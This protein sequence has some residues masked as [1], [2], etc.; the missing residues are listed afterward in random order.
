LK[1]ANRL[2]LLPI[3]ETNRIGKVVSS[4]QES[5]LLE[6]NGNLDF[7]FSQKM[8]RA[9]FPILVVRPKIEDAAR[10]LPNYAQGIGIEVS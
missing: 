8:K 1:S 5:Y 3:V 9:V 6:E 4:R 10:F 7:L 2:L